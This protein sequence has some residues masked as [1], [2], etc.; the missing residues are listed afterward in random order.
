LQTISY[1]R[2]DG[3]HHAVG[4]M[5]TESAYMA[6]HKGNAFSIPKCLGLWDNKI[7]KDATVVKMKKA[8]A[9]HKA[10]AEDYEIWKTA[11]DGCK[12]LICAAVEEVY[13]NKL[14][15]GTTFFHKVFACDLL[16]H[17]KK[18]STGLDAL[19]IV[20][21]HSNMLLL[22]KN[23][24]SMPDFIL[25][26]EEA[27]KKMKC[28]ELPILGIELAMYATT[29]ILQSGDCKKETDKWEGCSAAMKTWSKL[30]QA[31]LAAYARGINRHRAGA[32]D[33]RFSRAANLVTLPAAQHDGRPCRVVG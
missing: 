27:Q 11:E 14:K 20:A 31:Y 2:A 18:N 24:A 12:K 22:Y 25:A 21:L 32:T 1:D 5:Q 15:D 26:M 16:K 13:I 10:C 19:D 17:L 9:I 6:D 28:A 8:K 23:A 7:G 4:V 3:F 29:T 33:E 30:K